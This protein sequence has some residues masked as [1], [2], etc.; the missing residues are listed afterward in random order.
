MRGSGA[1]SISAARMWMEARSAARSA[2]SS[3]VNSPI[4]RARPRNW[5]SGHDHPAPL[6]VDRR[7]IGCCTR[8][9]RPCCIRASLADAFRA[10]YRAVPGGRGAGRRLS[11]AH[12]PAVRNVGAAGLVENKPGAGGN[13]GTE[14][15]A[16]SAPDGY[17]VLMAASRTR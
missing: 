17:T 12:R 10:L 2:R 15:V 6:R 1:A 9:R 16:R 7:R 4:R 14:T 13:V 8:T 11:R 5:E 3:C